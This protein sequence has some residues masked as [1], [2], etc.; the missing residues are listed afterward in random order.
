MKTIVD[1]NGNEVKMG[2][3]VRGKGFLRFQDNF[4]I[5]LTPVVTV[6]EH[7][8]RIYFGGLSME[9]FNEFYKVDQ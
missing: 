6:R 8:D 4:K 3:K 5:D 1:S 7:N 2:D 9:S